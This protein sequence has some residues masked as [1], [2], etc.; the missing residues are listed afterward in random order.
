M[1]VI[2]ILIFVHYKVILFVDNCASHPH[3]VATKLEAIKLVFFPT[4]MT[5]KL[6]PS[7]FTINCTVVHKNDINSK[8]NIV[9]FGS[10][11]LFFFLAQ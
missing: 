3:S 2:T 1:A 8:A 10:T 5:S 4:N 7:E 11:F 6:Q 9:Y